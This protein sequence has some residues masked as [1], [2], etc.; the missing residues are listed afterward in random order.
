MSYVSVA[1]KN[2]WKN[3]HSGAPIL[4]DK[5]R[6]FSEEEEEDDIYL[7]FGHL[8]IW[9]IFFGQTDWHTDQQTDRHTDRPTDRHRGS[10]GSYTSKNRDDCFLNGGDIR[11]ENFKKQ[12]R[13]TSS[14]SVTGDNI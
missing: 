11:F 10:K 2:W 14:G 12:G 1:T 3:A 8:K 4:V 9:T 5:R 6:V 13:S 7:K